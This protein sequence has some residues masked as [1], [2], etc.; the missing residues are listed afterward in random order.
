MMRAAV[1]LALLLLAGPAIA[2]DSGTLNRGNGA[3]PESLDPQFAGG[4]AE[5]EYPE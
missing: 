2:A 5:E 3:E 4:L 1:A